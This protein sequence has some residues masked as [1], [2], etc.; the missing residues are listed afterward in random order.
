MY[1]Q[2]SMSSNTLN[3]KASGNTE[4]KLMTAYKD[5][6]QAIL[7]EASEIIGQSD[8]FQDEDLQ[9]PNA[10]NQQVYAP[11]MAPSGGQSILLPQ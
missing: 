5:N 10:Y 9:Y 6:S 4:N 3:K 2:K 1:E 7:E 8:T 11:L